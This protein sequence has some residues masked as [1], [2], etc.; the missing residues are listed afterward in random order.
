MNFDDDYQALLISVAQHCTQALDRARLYEQSQR[1]RAEAETANRLKDEFVSTVSHELRTP[2]NAILGWASM[3]RTGSIDADVVPQALESVYRNASRQAKLVDDLLDFSRMAGGRTSLDLEPIEAASLIRGIVESLTPLAVSNQIE[4]A[5]SADP[6]ATVRGDVRRLEQV[7]VNLLGN[8]LKFT[9]AGGHIMVSARMVGRE[10]G[11]QGC[12][13]RQSGS[14]RNFCPT[15][16]IDF[17]RATVR[18]PGI[19]RAWGSGFPSQSSSSK[20]T[21]ARSG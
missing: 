1:A 11:G 7:F 5:L 4:I 13:R 12:R 20:R 21:R 19:I 9:P 14:R 3:L 15:S 18:R 10:P 17:G 8:A 16:S 2:L 6:E